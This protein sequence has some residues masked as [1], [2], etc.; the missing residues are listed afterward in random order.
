MFYYLRVMVVRE[1]I[2]VTG[3]FPAGVTRPAALTMELRFE[4]LKMLKESGWL[5]L[6]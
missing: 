4:I 3:T 5:F 6:K 2:D 1:N